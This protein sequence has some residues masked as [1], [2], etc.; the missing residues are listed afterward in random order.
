MCGIAGIFGLE[1]VTDPRAIVGR[2]NDAMAHRGPDAAGVMQV[3][4]AVLGHRRLS[5]FYM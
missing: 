5:I 2:M 4:N 3:A 1:R